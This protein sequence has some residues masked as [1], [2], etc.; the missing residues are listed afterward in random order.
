MEWGWLF[1]SL[2][3]LASS[4]SGAE[5]FITEMVTGTVTDAEGKA[6]EG[7]VV[8]F[9]RATDARMDLNGPLEATTNAEG[10]YELPLRFE[11]GKTL[12]VRELFADKAGYVR[13]APNMALPLSEGNPATQDFVLQ[14]GL[15]F[16]GELRIPVSFEERRSRVPPQDRQSLIQVMGPALADRSVNSRLYRTQ[17]GGKFE[18]Y[19]PEGEYSVEQAFTIG[20]QRGRWS[21]LK[22]GR[23]D[24]LLEIKPF[25]YVPSELAK[26]FDELWEVMDRRYSYFFLKKTVDWDRAKEIYRPKVMATR[27]AE[28]LTAVLVEMLTPLQDLHVWID[29]PSGRVP[30][31]RS[32]YDY[33]G[34]T[35]V[36]LE[37]LEDKTK[38]RDFAVVARTKEDGFGY[39]LMLRQSQA[40]PENVQAAVTAIE[41]LR[42][43]PGFIVDLRRANGGSEPLAMEIAKLFCAKPTVYGKSKMRSGPEHDDFGRINT[44]V[45]ASTPNAYT[46]PVVCLIGPG[47]V[48]SGEAFVKM[49]SCLP[50]V[51]TVGKNTRGASG[52]PQ[53][54]PF[55]DSGIAVYFSRWVDLMPSGLTFE[56]VGI[57]PDVL[58]DLPAETYRDRDPTFENGVEILRQKIGK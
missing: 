35:Q 56:G 49:M 43:A 13:G 50:Q 34:N 36:V 20:A 15:I 30:T 58:L 40:T 21:N 29:T 9:N 54:F 41:S 19:L 12:I 57:L 17:P 4:G 6:I 26:A 39:F 2:L 3:L 1:S 25:E 27:N 47:A 31:Y 46:R 7:A 16:A 44:R 42:D 11:S 5:N 10:K 22:S 53:P 18:I 48:S 33:N 24:L 51:T 45:L 38:L 23:K 8:R 14:P 37:A 55:G 28:E 52:N 32:E